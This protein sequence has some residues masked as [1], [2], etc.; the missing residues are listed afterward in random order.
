[1]ILPYALASRILMLQLVAFIAIGACIVSL[2]VCNASA[3]SPFA[4]D[5]S[6][7]DG[8]FVE[9]RPGG[10]LTVEL[11]TVEE[12]L[13]EHE[14]DKAPHSEPQASSENISPDQ[15]CAV[16]SSPEHQQHHQSAL[17]ADSFAER[18][19]ILESNARP[20]LDSRSDTP[21]SLVETPSSFIPPPNPPPPRA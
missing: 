5:L 3:Y 2:P 1:M 11:P 20:L 6:S 17:R 16:C 12:S 10:G 19:A 8:L 13:A 18:F 21:R 4:T 15:V 7:N 9:L 14:L